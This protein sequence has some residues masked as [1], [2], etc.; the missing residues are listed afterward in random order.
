VL[1]TLVLRAEARSRAPL[2]DR[3]CGTEA[4]T[5]TRASAG[6][7]RHGPAE[8]PG[9]GARGAE[10]VRIVTQIL[11]RR[12]WS[13]AD[14]ALSLRVRRRG[15]VSRVAAERSGPPA[16]RFRAHDGGCCGGLQTRTGFK[17]R[18]PRAE[19][20]SVRRRDQSRDWPP[21]LWGRRPQRLGGPG[22][23]P[24]RVGP[25]R[26]GSR[27]KGRPSHRPSGEGV[28]PVGRDPSPAQC[29]RSRLQDCTVC[30]RQEQPGPGPAAC[31]AGKRGPTPARPHSH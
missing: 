18:A 23:S 20:S 2:R 4:S 22:P 21:C 13:V 29:G 3:T 25:G 5:P 12:P 14:A 1:L 6:R 19:A 30:T 27:L 31:W 8:S 28:T 26:S 24:S 9:P 10:S 7:A 17:F 11:D 16:F 15:G